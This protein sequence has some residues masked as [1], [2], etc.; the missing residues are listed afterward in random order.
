M[1]QPKNTHRIPLD[2]AEPTGS[3]TKW[4]PLPS[5]TEPKDDDSDKEEYWYLFRIVLLCIMVFSFAG[6]VGQMIRA[7]L[8]GECS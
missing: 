8:L 7:S 5:D 6:F 4:E 3:D 2:Y 1:N